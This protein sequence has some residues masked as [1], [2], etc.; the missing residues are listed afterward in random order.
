[1]W[2]KPIQGSRRSSCSR[3]AGVVVFRCWV[4]FRCVDSCRRARGLLTRSVCNKVVCLARSWAVGCTRSP[5][6]LFTSWRGSMDR[7]NGG[8]ACI[9]DHRRNCPPGNCHLACID[10]EKL[11]SGNG[12]FL[13]CSLG[14]VCHA[15]S[16][17]PMM[18]FN[19]GMHNLHDMSSLPSRGQGH[20]MGRCS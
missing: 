11:L 2:V 19:S 5:R 9:N 10:D 3:L 14:T 6:V 4:F 18:A 17:S 12:R 8:S 13:A 16:C 15:P 7:V 20:G 1:M